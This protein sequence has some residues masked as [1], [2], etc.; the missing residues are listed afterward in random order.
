MIT[1]PPEFVAIEFPGYYFNTINCTLY[2]IKVT[3]VLRPLPRRCNKWTH[4]NDGYQI[5]FN[6]KKRIVTQVAL[7]R[8]VSQIVPVRS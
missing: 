2:T 3:G 8:L 7:M 6:G 1:F 4:W 5:S